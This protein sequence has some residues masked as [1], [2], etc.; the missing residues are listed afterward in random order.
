MDFRA[1]WESTLSEHYL[2]D[3]GI[4]VCVCVYVCVCSHCAYARQF[5]TTVES[6]VVSEILRRSPRV[7]KLIVLADVARPNRLLRCLHLV[8][9]HTQRLRWL[10]DLPF[11]NVVKGWWC[12]Y[13][14]WS[15]FQWRVRR[16]L[17]S[18]MT[19]L[20]FHGEFAVDYRRPDEIW[21]SLKTIFLIFE[22]TF[23]HLYFQELW[24]G[25]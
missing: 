23:F 24:V 17:S 8:H 7:N 9:T 12:W 3:V 21:F 13:W 15:L 1:L 6:S 19:T 16:K 4:D 10:K 11:G 5:V 18:L 25:G 20:C 14:C 22:T 2:V